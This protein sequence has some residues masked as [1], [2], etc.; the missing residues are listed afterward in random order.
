MSID[1]HTIR[2]QIYNEHMCVF[3]LRGHGLYEKKHIGN[4]LVYLILCCVKYN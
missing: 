3:W 1:N 4:I 2:I